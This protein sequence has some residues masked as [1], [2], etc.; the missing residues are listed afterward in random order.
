MGFPSVG[1]YL[2][3]LL[4]CSIPIVVFS[5]QD[6]ED[7]IALEN[8]RLYITRL[9][10]SYIDKESGLYNGRQ[11]VVYAHTIS[12]GTPFL[13]ASNE[14]DNGSIEYDG[15]LYENV[16]LRYD[17]LKNMIVT[18]VPATNYLVQLNNEKTTAFSIENR[19]FKKLE[20]DT[21]YNT[22][23]AGFYEILYDGKC[24][25]YKKQLK[26]LGEDLSGSKL[27][28]FII[29][30]TDYYLQKDNRYIVINNR[31][32]LLAAF[33]DKKKDIQSFLK[34]NKLNFRDDKDGVLAKT[35]AYYDQL[36]TTHTN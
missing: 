26:T 34:K 23:K 12:E 7:S 11:Y 2:K 15:I 36:S 19:H 9:H 22:L 20:K 17:I 1:R 13:I 18:R 35:A 6:Q 10:N 16:P 30:A 31:K 3:M 21:A 24:K 28:T 8:A 5:Q 33:R 29:D 25:A 32:A 4:F 14:M 27:R